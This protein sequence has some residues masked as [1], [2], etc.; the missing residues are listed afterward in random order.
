MDEPSL[1]KLP[2]EEKKFSPP[3]KKSA[4]E[5]IGIRKNRRYIVVGISIF[6]AVLT[7]FLLIPVIPETR[8]KAL[9]TILQMIYFVGG[10]VIV[11]YFGGKSWEHREI[12]NNKLKGFRSNF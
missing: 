10:S 11:A 4:E 7:V 1:P 12:I 9:D 3:S 5:E 2:S 6:L 8:I